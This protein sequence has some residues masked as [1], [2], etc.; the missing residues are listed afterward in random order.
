[1]QP[2][3][4]RDLG[5]T[6][7][8]VAHEAAELVLR[9]WRLGVRPNEKARADLVTEY[10]LASERLVRARLAERTP[11]ASRSDARPNPVA[12]AARAL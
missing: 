10:D 5:Q 6:A 7:L 2:E 12:T 4:L 3:R 1:M 8:A 9:G 11:R